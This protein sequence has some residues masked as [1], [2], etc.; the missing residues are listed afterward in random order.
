[1]DSLR[2]SGAL[3]LVAAATSAGVTIVFREDVVW[4]TITLAA[5]VIAAVIGVLLLR[6]PTSTLILLSSIGGIAWVVMYGILVA[7]QSDDIQAWTADAFL[8]VIGAVA[9][10]V[11]NGPGRQATR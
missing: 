7:L 2:T 4:Y 10:F 6:R 5:G 3:W 1:M 8:G 11:A 9:A